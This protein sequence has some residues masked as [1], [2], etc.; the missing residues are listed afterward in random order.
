MHKGQIFLSVGQGVADA[1]LSGARRSINLEKNVKIKDAL[2]LHLEK[3]VTNVVC[4][5]K[6]LS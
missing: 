5:E 2:C 6:L 4:H 1:P 3:N